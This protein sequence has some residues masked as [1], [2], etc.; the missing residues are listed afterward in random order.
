M[1]EEWQCTCKKVEPKKPE[2]EQKPDNSIF[3]ILLA[4]LAVLGLGGLGYEKASHLNSHT[5]PP[6]RSEN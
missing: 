2:P 6:H 5:H 4:F 1:A 3:L